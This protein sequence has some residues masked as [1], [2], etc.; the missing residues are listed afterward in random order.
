M[1]Y[2]QLVH[3]EARAGRRSLSTVTD[4][5]Q[6]LSLEQK[7]HWQAGQGILRSPPIHRPL[8]G[9]VDT[10]SSESAQDVNAFT[11]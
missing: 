11:H 1:E 10:L 7:L 4:L 5:R 3:T 2:T 6:G 9:I 8:A